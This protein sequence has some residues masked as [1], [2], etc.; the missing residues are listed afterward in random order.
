MSRIDAI[1]QK[2]EMLKTAM[3]ERMT[4]LW[5]ASESLSI[6]R[7]GETTVAEATGLSRDTIC[8]GISEFEEVGRSRRR[9]SCPGSE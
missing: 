3:N 8:A 1:R 9:R 2:Y 6:G 5:A 4:R 7:G